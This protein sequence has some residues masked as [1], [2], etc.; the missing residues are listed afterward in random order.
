M[1]RLSFLLTVFFVLAF[2][3]EGQVRMERARFERLDVMQRAAFFEPHIATVAAQYDVDPNLL[4]TIAYLETRFRPWLTSQKGARGLMQFMPDTAERFS[5]RDPYDPVSS[6]S[7]AAKYLRVLSRMFDG[8]VES[9][10]A[11]YNAG[12]G[13]VSAF[14]YG[15]ILQVDGKV[16][17]RSAIK[18]FGGVPPYLET[19]EYVRQGVEIYRWLRSIR[20]FESPMTVKSSDDTQ[21]KSVDDQAAVV[22][23]RTVFYDART[24]LRYSLSDKTG[25]TKLSDPGAIIISP[26]VHPTVTASAR[27]SYFGKRIEVQK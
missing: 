8:R 19:R 23:Y 9:I 21:D 13:T 14:L 17:N 27:T 25:M 20:K 16:I 26:N 18:T 15:R 2:S 7:S 12:E 11:A 22:E 10:L 4:W 1:M 3:V 24:G 5:L 6:L